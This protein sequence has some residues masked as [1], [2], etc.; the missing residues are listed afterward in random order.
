MSLKTIRAASMAAALAEVKREVGPDAVILRTR[1][2]KAGGVM[3]LG[4]RSLIEVTASSAA[5]AP[6]MVRRRPPRRSP[7]DASTQGSAPSPA[8]A[9]PQ[10]TYDAP[11][12][13]ITGADRPVVRRSPALEALV[14]PVRANPQNEQARKSLEDEIAGIKRLVGQL[15]HATRT[16]PAPMVGG[17][18]GGGLTIGLGGASDTL[19]AAYGRLIDGELSPDLAD[20]VLTQVRRELSEDEA[21][22]A[23]IVDR[24]VVRLLAEKL[25]ADARVLSEPARGSRIVFVG[26]TGVGKTTSIAKLAAT[27]QLR[28]GLSVGLITADTYRI[29]AVDQL[30]TYAGI[31]GVPLRVAL[32]PEELSAAVESLADRDVILIDTAGRSP[33]DASR[34]EEL[35]AFVRAANPDVTCLAL[36]ANASERTLRGVIGRFEPLHPT[37]LAVTK[38][39]EAE[40]LGPALSAA[41]S[42]G[43]PIAMLS[44][45]QEVPDQF[46]WARAERLASLAFEG[47]R[48]EPGASAEGPMAGAPA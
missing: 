8:Q 6:P 17:G 2:L 11:V 32:T 4:A 30:R 33:K 28:R 21:Q 10:P 42:C 16:G 46:E 48:A 3:G 5:D 43:R 39:D 40:T 34:L 36:A 13:P 20:A 26:P 31:I 29:A 14:T 15:L 9:P 44:T 27:Y 7:A 12:D 45:G 41:A 22:D 23:E 38:A 25:S 24:S 37:A 47:S 19:H 1:T 35:S 18:V